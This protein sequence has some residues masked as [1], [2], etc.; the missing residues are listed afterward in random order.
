[1]AVEPSLR[2]ATAE[3]NLRLRQENDRLLEENTKLQATL[4]DISNDI[5]QAETLKRVAQK[6][7]LNNIG[8]INAF[9]I[10]TFGLGI[11]YSLLEND[12]RAVAALYYYDLGPDV[13]P[14]FARATVAL[15]L[16]LRLPGELLHQYEALVPQNPVFYKAC[17][18]G[19]AYLFG[20][21]VSQACSH[22]VRA[23]PARVG[24]LHKATPN[25]A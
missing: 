16:F 25:L 12:I 5:L 4:E 18:S 24:A 20:D 23:R 21:F 8:T 15:D 11:A 14:G 9:I 22:R 13:Y 19:V 6:S 7:L 10:I 3:E 17:T 1:M 2:A